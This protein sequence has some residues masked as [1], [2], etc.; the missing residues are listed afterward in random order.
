MTDQYDKAA[1]ADA[2]AAFWDDYRKVRD[3]ALAPERSAYH[4]A[5]A[6]Y[7]ESADAYDKAI[8]D[9]DKAQAKARGEAR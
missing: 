1:L 3:K 6:S 8:T 7:N 9:Y 5:Q 2:R 4:K